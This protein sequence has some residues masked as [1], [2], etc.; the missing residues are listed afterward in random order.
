MSATNALRALLETIR[1]DPA[2]APLFEGRVNDRQP[3]DPARD[4]FGTELPEGKLRVWLG[5]LNV[6][7]GDECRGHSGQLRIFVEGNTQSRAP[8]WDAALAVASALSGV[9]N[10]AFGTVAILR[11][12]ADVLDDKPEIGVAIDIGFRIPG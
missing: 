9:S 12:L 7:F 10:S 6:T 2:C 11:P 8:V 3:G 5:P 1:D 4:S